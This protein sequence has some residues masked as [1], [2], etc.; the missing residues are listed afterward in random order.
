[1][2]NDAPESAY[3]LGYTT[4][5]HGRLMRQA[6][7]V[8][9]CTE[10]L[11]RTAGIGPGDRVLDLGSGVGDVSILLSRLVGPTGVVVGVERDADSIAKAE[12]R[13]ATAGIQNVSFVQ[14]EASDPAV[15]GMFDA[16]AGRFIL[17]YLPDPAGAL[18]LL[19]E[20]LRPHGAVAFLEP[21]WASARGILAHMPLYSSC[22][23]AIVETLK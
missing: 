12:G 18:R 6:A 1:M 8:A 22:T 7:L 15:S 17:M 4:E 11:F 10:R 21:S 9:P 3:A 16:I 13:L 20:R 14:S 23:T 2:A 19:L 5:E